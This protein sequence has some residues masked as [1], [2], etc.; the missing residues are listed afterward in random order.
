M[1]A[2]LKN[3]IKNIL[4]ISGVFF[5]IFI[6]SNFVFI[7]FENARIMMLYLGLFFWVYTLPFELVTMGFLISIIGYGYLKEKRD[8]QKRGS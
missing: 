1:K 3:V 2:M 7:P 6:I 5:W 4:Y 8:A